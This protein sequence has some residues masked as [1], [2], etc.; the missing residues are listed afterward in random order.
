[1]IQFSNRCCCMTARWC[2]GTSNL[3]VYLNRHQ[4]KCREREVGPGYR[5]NAGGFR[6]LGSTAPTSLNDSVIGERKGDIES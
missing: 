5:T 1:M 3:S 2:V 4:A 6:G